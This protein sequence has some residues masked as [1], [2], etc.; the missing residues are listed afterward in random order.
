VRLCSSDSCNSLLISISAA[1]EATGC[2][3]HIEFERTMH[4][5]RQCKPLAEEYTAT[6]NEMFGTEIKMYFH[7]WSGGG[8]STDFGN[9]SSSYPPCLGFVLTT[10][11]SIRTYSQVT[12]ALPACHPHFGI[13][14][15][16]GRGAHT[17]EFEGSARGEQAHEEAFRAAT[18][19][20]S[21][22]LKVL[23]DADFLAQVGM[24]IYLSL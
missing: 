20:A 16:L 8:A 7:D 24:M 4:D 6:M 15:G 3:V 13:P 12:Y 17:P 11:K 10:W 2:E 1:A 21:V 14:Y 22:G 19:I 9:V 18:G 23:T 5:L